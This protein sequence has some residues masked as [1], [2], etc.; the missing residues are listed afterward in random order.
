MYFCPLQRTWSG[1]QGE[2][3]FPDDIEY[4]CGK[5]IGTDTGFSLMGI[6]PNKIH[7]IPAMSRLTK[8]IKQYET[9]RHKNVFPESVK[10]RL[11]EPG[12]EFTLIQRPGGT[13]LFRPVQYAK[14]K[15]EGIDGW[16]NIWKTH[17][18][19]G[20][21]PV[22]L[23]I[24]ALTA[25]GPYDAPGNVTLT[26]FSEASD[27]SDRAAADQVRADLQPSSDQVKIGS[28]SGCYTAT[29]QCPE[30]TAADTRMTF[31][32]L[33]HGVMTRTPNSAWA[34]MAKKF[35]PPLDLSLYQALGVWVYGDGKG[36]V[37]NFQ[38]RSPEHV[39]TGIGEHYVIVDF[40]GW[41]YVE[42]IEPE[43]RRYADYVWPYGASAYHIYR[44]CVQYDQ[45]AF[46]GL[47]Y[48][49]LP[50]NEPVTCY[51]SPIRALPLLKA[52]LRRPAVTIGG[53]KIVFPTEIESGCYL[54]F[55][56]ML[57]CKLYG[58][59]G[60]LIREVTPEGDVPILEAGENTITFTCDVQ[61]D[62]N[63]RAYVT[64]ITQGEPLHG[65]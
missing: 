13:Y 60:E 57:D 44:E 63:A 9:L 26:D 45:V 64:V 20:R 18:T 32:P 43:G 17:N 53:R 40:E 24:E 59:Q 58:P 7:K 55:R 27:F 62:V 46:L 65:D 54:G 33:E 12:E 38:V 21:Q 15:V 3:T 8:I 61:G 51:L 11:R 23:R 4:L 6:D 50:P 42:L 47:W 25:A 28:I 10:A 2:P 52:T 5:C 1:A 56:S 49:N 29:N 41:R 30:R 36:E 22:G 14:H 16:S 48:N 39:S 37:L 31:S 35:S 34:K 19:F